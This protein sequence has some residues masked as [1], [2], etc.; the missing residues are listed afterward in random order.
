MYFQ[1]VAFCSGDFNVHV[2]EPSSDDFS[3]IS[4]PGQMV[5]TLLFK[6]NIHVVIQSLD[7]DSSNC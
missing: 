6:D 3:T 5:S 1:V 4:F 7:V 2:Y